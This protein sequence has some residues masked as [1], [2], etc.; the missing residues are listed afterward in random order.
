MFVPHLKT[1]IHL[2]AELEVVRTERSIYADA[3]DQ[4]TLATI[5]LDENGRVLHANR[6]GRHDP[7]RA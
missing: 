5:V 2:F 6:L 1:A 3:M 4:L 7:R